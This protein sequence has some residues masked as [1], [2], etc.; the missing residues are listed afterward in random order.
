MTRKKR[1]YHREEGKKRDYHLFAI[2][3]EG[4]VRERDYFA[5]FGQLSSRVVVRL[6]SDTDEEGQEVLS[7]NSSPEHVM[8]RARVYSESIELGEGDHLWLVL[9]VDRW[10]EK[11]L[12]DLCATAYT[13]DWMVAISNPCFEVW[14][15]YHFEDA[16]DDGGETRNSAWFKHHLSTRREG[17]YNA[18]IDARKAFKAAA[19]ARAK[20]LNPAMRIPP[21]KVTQVY[22]LIE[23][24]LSCCS[25]AD[26]LCFTER[27][28]TIR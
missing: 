15:C 18:K 14:L 16:I 8:E 1:P 11:Q 10:K 6:L 19:I 22:R 25:K 13:R 24:M 9:D 5:E 23:A 4:S 20:D 26:I 27:K 28:D 21:Y 12:S 7:T 17:G 3:C 2:A